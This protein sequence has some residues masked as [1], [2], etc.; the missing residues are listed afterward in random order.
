M[1]FLKFKLA[2]TKLKSKPRFGYN[3]IG[4]P[5]KPEL[6]GLIPNDNDYNIGTP[7]L[8][9]IEDVTIVASNNSTKTNLSLHLKWRPQQD[10]GLSPKQLVTLVSKLTL[11]LNDTL[12]EYEQIE[13]YQPNVS[14]VRQNYITQYGSTSSNLKF[15]ISAPYRRMRIVFHGNMKSKTM[16]QNDNTGSVEDL[17]TFVKLNLVIC[18]TGQIFDFYTL[19]DEDCF[20]KMYYDNKI[21]RTIEQTL[22]DLQFQ[23]RHEQ[24][25]RATGE[26]IIFKNDD[27]EHKTKEILFFW[28]FLARSYQALLKTLAGRDKLETK[29]ILGHLVNGQAFHVG[30]NK[31]DNDK[32]DFGYTCFDMKPDTKPIEKP[33]VIDW[34]LIDENCDKFELQVSG[35]GKTFDVL[36]RKRFGNQFDIEMNGK[37]GC[38]WLFFNNLNSENSDE[39]LTAIQKSYN[40][41]QEGMKSGLI[42]AINIG[43]QIYN[44][45]QERLIVNINDL[46]CTSTELVGSKAASLALLRLLSKRELNFQVPD[47]IVLTRFAHD[48]FLK[49]NDS[50]KTQ[51]EKL[52][53]LIGSGDIENLELECQQLQALVEKAEFPA[54]FRK[55]LLDTLINNFDGYASDE[56]T[57]AVRSS[58]WGEDEEDMSAAGQ[59]STILGVTGGFEP[60]L[61]AVRKC[62]ASKFNYANVEYK[63]Q[64]GLEPSLPMAVV[65]QRMVECEKAGVMF[66]CD[67][68]TGD[69]KIITITANYGLGESVV[70]GQSEPD[71]IVVERIGD[72]KIK[73]IKLGEKSIVIDAN[74]LKGDNNSAPIQYDKSKCCLNEDESLKLANCGINVSKYFQNQRD[75]E[76]GFKGNQLYL[77]QSRPVTGLDAFSEHELIHE[78]E[79]PSRA[80]LEFCTRANIGEVMP[81]AITPFTLTC[82][83][84][85]WNLGGYRYLS[86]LSKEM[87]GDM[88]RFSPECVYEII[89][90]SYHNLFRLRC[91]ILFP[92]QQTKQEKSITSKSMEMAFFGHEIDE[93]PEIVEASLGFS[94]PSNPFEGFKYR[95]QTLGLRWRPMATI[96]REKSVMANLRSDV[97]LLKL[98][99]GYNKNKMFGLYEQIKN[100]YGHCYDC[101]SKHIMVIMMAGNTNTELSNFL[102]NYIKDPIKLFTAVSKLLGTSRDV[103]SAEIPERINKM[104]MIIK[105]KGS[106]ERDKFL[107]MST[108]EALD[109]IKNSDESLS[110]EFK[111]FIERFGHRCYNE[112][113]F[114][115]KSWAEDKGSILDMLKKNCQLNDD[116]IEGGEKNSKRLANLDEVIES[117][118]IKLSKKDYFILRNFLGPKCNL[119]V[120]AREQTKD[121]LVEFHDIVRVASRMLANELR[122][123]KRLPDPELFYYLFYDE[124]EPLIREPQPSL[125]VQATRRRNM[126]R[127]VYKEPWR[128]DEIIA[129]YH[130]I[131]NHLKPNKELAEQVSNAPKLFGSTASYGKVQAKVCLVH[132]YKDLNKVRAGDILVTH[133]TDIA[134]SPVFPLIV[135]IITEVGGLISHGAV[136][137]REYGLPSVLSVPNVTRILEDGEE[138]VLDADSGVII[139]LSK[140]VEVGDN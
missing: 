64:H 139:R 117:L 15:I 135:G 68:T 122:I 53:D 56:L 109:Y 1:D 14:S 133:S 84:F 128:F 81:F 94:Q 89:Y 55:E 80:E 9:R 6:I 30:L 113:E 123:N 46:I 52:D 44:S 106:Q 108:N 93:Q 140:S 120:A 119:M 85:Y 87:A 26:C 24:L 134:F 96:M 92:L 70:S 51:I 97:E 32:L 42:S 27:S 110:K 114:K 124:I 63:R 73:Q 4:D 54:N 22:T 129:G 74:S 115:E 29:R 50:L 34:A 65:I 2:A 103:I 36:A 10:S 66:T 28:G 82:G 40:D 77:F 112:F 12:Y 59:L 61:A 131:P 126:F 125:V 136:V 23:D 132:N 11:T 118:D 62:F 90:D 86:S 105:G 19:F 33:T 95:W 121:I 137:A 100:I 49:H 39:L 72:L 102:S 75:I 35:Q 41:M 43:S 78:C 37:P 67:P 91:S 104:A 69:D 8:S 31:I 99:T 138:I 48:A 60:I 7:S 127:K 16:K 18:P 76:W 45:A 111:L 25:I 57:L 5:T 17:L 116:L 98:A 38:A 20:R 101:W 107:A 58:S 83:I 79:Q 47:G 130:L 13:T 21:E 3:P 71:L 88:R